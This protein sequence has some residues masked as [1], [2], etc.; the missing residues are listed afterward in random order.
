MAT[1]SEGPAV[2]AV[3][4]AV[5]GEAA[6]VADHEEGGEGEGGAGEEPWPRAMRHEGGSTEDDA[7]GQA[8]EKDGAPKAALT[9]AGKAPGRHDV[10]PAAL[11][12]VHVAFFKPTD[13]EVHHRER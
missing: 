1:G 7:G 10:H 11:G 4:A 2:A 12:A 6:A 5:D 3:Q 8:Y 13:Q 9:G